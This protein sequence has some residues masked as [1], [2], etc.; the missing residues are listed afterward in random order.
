MEQEIYNDD[1]QD[2]TETGSLK[3]RFERTQ[4]LLLGGELSDIHNKFENSQKFERD[5]MLQNIAEKDLQF[6]KQFRETNDLINSL[7]NRI[8]LMEAEIKHLKRNKIDIQKLAIVLSDLSLQLMNISN[9]E[10]D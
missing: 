6:E 3:Y 1:Q 2:Q 10:T 7:T 5:I 8:V 9:N 4:K